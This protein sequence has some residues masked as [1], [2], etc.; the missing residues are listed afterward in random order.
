MILYY[1][2]VKSHLCKQNSA[3]PDAFYLGL[4]CLQRYPYRG[5][6]SKINQLKSTF[7]IKLIH[8]P[9]KALHRVIG[10]RREKT[11]LRGFANNKGAGQPAHPRSLISAFVIRLLETIIHEGMISE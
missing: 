7:D 9:H 4:Y 3:D 11:C 10:P 2:F 6:R 5:F 8:E 1:F